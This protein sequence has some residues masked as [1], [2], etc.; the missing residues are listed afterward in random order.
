MVQIS[1]IIVT[2]LIAIIGLFKSHESK[3][4]WRTVTIVLLI[5]VAI[6]Q[7]LIVREKSEGEER[8]MQRLAN[9]SHGNDSLLA[10]N[11]A[12]L[13]KNDELVEKIDKYQEQL[14]KQDETVRSIRDFAYMARL[15]PNGK[16]IQG[17]EGLTYTTEISR[18]IEPALL[19]KDGKIFFKCDENSRR[20]YEKAIETF[21]RFPFSYVGLAECYRKRGDAK[22]KGYARQAIDILKKTTQIDGH[23][24]SHKQALNQLLG[25]LR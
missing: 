12:F 14:E 13:R 23:Q 8:L 25:Y 11:Q 19:V 4:I 24:I 15:D 16:S 5:A 3:S 9:L 17:G 18:I 20:R 1:L 6:I 22:W 2:L 10:T 7:F 21:P